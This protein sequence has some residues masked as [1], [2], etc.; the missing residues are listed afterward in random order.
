MVADLFFIGLL[1][2]T[3]GAVSIIMASKKK[4][5]KITVHNTFDSEKLAQDIATAVGR[6]VAEQMKAVLDS[7]PAGDYRSTTKN[8][9]QE[10]FE[11][12]M[13]ESIIPV[14]LDMKEIESNLTGMTKKEVKVDKDL[15]KSKSKLK[16]LLG[17]KKK[18]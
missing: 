2:I 5:D 4:Q 10:S 1:V 18:E 12:E 14:N 11:I 6:E 17:K 7:L 15:N 8:R 9:S 16:A 3:L 13:D